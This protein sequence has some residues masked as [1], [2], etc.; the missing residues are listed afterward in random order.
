MPGDMVVANLEL[1]DAAWVYS[2]PPHEQFAEEVGSITGNEMALVV[3]TN[4]RTSSMN[5]VYA[6]TERSCGWMITS[7]LKKVC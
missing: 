2:L 7:V 5:I 4:I 1:A 3:A 6:V